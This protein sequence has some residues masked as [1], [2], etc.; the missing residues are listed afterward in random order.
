MYMNNK[1]G[2]I[3]DTQQ[4][5][6]QP[7]W[8]R[9]EVLSLLAIALLCELAVSVMNIAVMPVYL[10]YQRGF[11]EGVTGLVIMSFLLS[12]AI[13]KG[14]MGHLSDKRGRR[15]MLILAPLIWTFT[16]IAT[17]LVPN[18]W[19][20]GAAIAMIGL[21]ILDGVSAAMLWPSAY[22]A[23]ADVVKENER[24]SSLSLLNVCFMMGLA[25][26]FPV[27]G[28]MKA[29]SSNYGAGL[30]AS[31][32]LFLSAA[33]VAFFLKAQIIDSHKNDNSGQDYHLRDLWNC[34]KRVPLMF[35]TAFVTFLGVG[36]PMV[37]LQWFAK[38]EFGLPQEKFGLLVLPAGIAM[39]IMSFPLGSLGEKV[40]RTKAVKTGLLFCSIGIWMIALGAFFPIFKFVLFLLLGAVLVGVGF[41]LAIPS[42]YATVSRI[43]TAR[44]G[45]YLGAIMTVQGIGAIIGLGVGSKLYEIGNYA[46]MIACGIAILFG[47]SLSLVALEHANSS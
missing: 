27:A 11:S 3:P 20:G 18:E 44:S 38:D 34:A 23:V 10:R 31:A 21:R 30:Y 46:P 45:S 1:S 25:L 42:W 8:M 22:A 15:I 35:I 40:G 9:K 4:A 41:L 26:G 5:K 47:F 14:Y 6:H 16:P 2:G 37:S 28:T 19:G 13:F 32:L 39:A 43:D 24:A 36:F 7:I 33:I 17:L 12:E 29:V